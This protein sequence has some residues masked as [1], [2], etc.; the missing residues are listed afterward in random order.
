MT[1]I[2]TLQAIVTIP[3]TSRKSN[4]RSLVMLQTCDCGDLDQVGLKSL[5]TTCPQAS[6]ALAPVP[7]GQKA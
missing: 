2:K 1:M 6:R 5:V 4:F 3:A 7:I